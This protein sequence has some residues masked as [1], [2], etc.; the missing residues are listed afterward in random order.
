MASL[1]QKCCKH[2]WVIYTTLRLQRIGQGL[3][4]WKALCSDKSLPPRSEHVELLYWWCA[5]LE[6]KTGQSPSSRDEEGM[7]SME[8][9]LSANANPSNISFFNG[10]CLCCLRMTFITLSPTT[11]LSSF[12]F[13]FF[14]FSPVPLLFLFSQLFV[15]LTVLHESIFPDLTPSVLHGSTLPVPRP[16]NDLKAAS[17]GSGSPPFIHFPH[18]RHHYPPQCLAFWNSFAVFYL[19]STPLW[20]GEYFH[21]FIAVSFQML[22]GQGIESHKFM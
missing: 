4:P 7:Q 21:S 13:A 19:V 22:T 17:W 18:L 3:S 2:A 20:I 11:F 6:N 15:Y 5:E 14:F 16:G 10:S 8:P 1:L 9:V 12:Q